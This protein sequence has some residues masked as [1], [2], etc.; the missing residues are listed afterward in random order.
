MQKLSDP[1]PE[2]GGR[3]W[4]EL[5]VVTHGDGH[6][7]FADKIRR[8]KRDGTLEEIPVRVRVVRVKELAE[9]RAETRAW[10]ARHKELDAD[11]D[12]DLFDDLEQVC[13]LAHAV[14][15]NDPPYSQFASADELAR[16]YDEASLQDLIGR[17]NVMRQL[18][19]PRESCLTPDQVW[20][21]I[22]AVAKRGHLLPLTDIAG[23]EQPSCVV[24]M[25]SQA[26]LS[27]MGQSWQRSFESS[28]PAPSEPKN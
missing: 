19:D 14:R 15:T 4:E 10:F 5:E 2:L 23:H 27:P 24:F 26:L 7:L 3:T 20:S 6:L 16:D 18:I 17:I 22:F 25:A 12:K 21:K 9:A 1:I 13:I 11:R 28:M 8:R